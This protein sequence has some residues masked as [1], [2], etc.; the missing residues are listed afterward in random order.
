[1]GGD[2]TMGALSD[3]PTA[4]A[5]G[6]P[7]VLTVNGAAP[8]DIPG[9]VD[10]IVERYHRTHER[11]LP[12]TTRLARQV[13]QLYASDPNCPVGL[14]DHLTALAAHLEA[15]HWREETILF[16]LLRIGTPHCLEF[17]IRRMT[18]DHVDIELELMTLQRLTKGY[19][20]SFEAPFC[21]QALHVMCRKL[22]SDLRE[23]TRLEHEVLYALL[24]S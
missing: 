15:H 8:Y 23:H 14:A 10:H 24:V 21:W 6:N 13:E 22:E 1:M 9:L 11:E 17:V 2:R 5:L 3:R 7:G 18:A 16:P 19:R 20:P 12:C 4:A